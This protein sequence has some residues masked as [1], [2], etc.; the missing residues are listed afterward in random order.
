MCPRCEWVQDWSDESRS[1]GLAGK[2]QYLRAIGQ[3]TVRFNVTSPDGTVKSV[4]VYNVLCVHGLK[5]NLLSVARLVSRIKCVIFDETGARIIDRSDKVLCSAELR[6]GSFCL[7]TAMQDYC[8]VPPAAGFTAV[9]SSRKDDLSRLWHRRLGHMDAA[10]HDQVKSRVDGLGTGPDIGHVCPECL[11][12]RQAAKPYGRTQGSSSTAPLEL[13]HVDLIG[14]L[15]VESLGGSRFVLTIVDDFSRK[16]F[17]FFL[18]SKADASQRLID[19][20]R[21]HEKQMPYT[22]KRVRTDRAGYLASTYGCRFSGEQQRGRESEPYAYGYRT[23]F[24]GRFTLARSVLGEAVSGAAYLSG[25]RPA[26]RARCRTVQQVWNGRRPDVSHLRV[27]GCLCYVKYG[28]ALRGKLDARGE[29]AIF[30]GYAPDKQSCRVFNP[31]ARHVT[32]ECNVVFHEGQRGASLLDSGAAPSPPANAPPPDIYFYLPLGGA[33]STAQ[34]P[35]LPPPLPPAPDPPAA[36]VDPR[37]ADQGQRDLQAALV[38]VPDKYIK[39]VL[40]CFGLTDYNAA[41]TSLSTSV[42]LANFGESSPCDRTLYQQMLGCLQYIVQG[43]RPDLA[44]PVSCL[45]QYAK[46]PRQIHLTAIKWVMQFIKSTASL[47]LALGHKE[48]VLH[49]FTDASWDSTKD[50]KGFGGPRHLIQIAAAPPASIL[51]CIA[52]TNFLSLFLT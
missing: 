18:R 27:F 6:L 19:F 2:E 51:F 16:V 11:V 10:Y 32:I 13:L 39:T 7:R 21:Y 48:D 37:V 8:E 20:V 29:P 17:V 43:S 47:C 41:R 22:V 31:R 24:I 26:R 5:H 35:P 28:K 14:A 38:I 9:V 12:G 45:S 50:A 49:V 34:A 33:T 44:F 40:G 4:G 52:K 3:S 23:Y 15:P 46:D 42:D 30:V 1:V 36:A 25:L